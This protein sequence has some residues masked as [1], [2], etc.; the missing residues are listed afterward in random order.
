MEGCRVDEL[1][2]AEDSE[3]FSR[4]LGDVQRAMLEKYGDPDGAEVFY[5][6][7]LAS[8]GL[9][10]RQAKDKQSLADWLNEYLDAGGV[11]FRLVPVS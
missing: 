11:A 7:M 4:A 9:L 2:T 8:V 1:F 10:L 6:L 3:V 5:G